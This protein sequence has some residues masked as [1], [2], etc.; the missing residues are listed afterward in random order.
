LNWTTKTTTDLWSPTIVANSP[1]TAG[2]FFAR[3]LAQS[4][5]KGL[6][7]PFISDAYQL[8][9]YFLMDT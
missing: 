2:D 9:R 4:V 8:K 7:A 3:R 6:P 1:A 5:K